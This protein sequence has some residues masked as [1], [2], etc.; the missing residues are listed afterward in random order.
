[1]NVR[2]EIEFEAPTAEDEA[3]LSSVA[4]SLANKSAKRAGCSARRQPALV[5]RGV[6]DAD[7][8]TIQGSGPD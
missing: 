5:G 1:M 6:H 8:G 7:R 2:L 4:R 3:A